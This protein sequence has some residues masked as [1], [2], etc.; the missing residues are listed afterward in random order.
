[1]KPLLVIIAVIAVAALPCAAQ[2]AV[3]FVNQPLIPASVAPGG[4]GFT[5]TVNGTGFV[6]GSTVNWNGSPRTT[7]FISGSQVTANIL[8]TD[9]ATATT[10]SITVFSPAPGGGTSN[11]VFLP[12]RESS[13]F[14]SLNTSN[15]EPE[16]AT[17]VLAAADF[18]N[19]GKQDL[20]VATD[21]V[22]SY[23]IQIL[24]GNGDG[25]F[26][27]SAEYTLSRPPFGLLI[28]DLNG[29]GNLDLVATDLV[30]S[31]N[32]Q[33]F[34]VFLG[35]GD[36]TFQQPVLYDNNAAC[37]HAALVDI[38]RDGNLDVVALYD[39]L[40]CVS[41]GNGNGSFQPA[42][43]TNNLPEQFNYFAVGDLNA[44][45]KLDLAMTGQSGNGSYYLGILLGNGNG[46]FQTAQLTTLTNYPEGITT[47]DFNGDGILDLAVADNG[48]SVVL[49]FLG[50]GDGTFRTPS[51]LPV[52]LEP[53]GVSAAD[54][55]GDGKLDLVVGDYGYAL[56]SLSILLGNGDGTFQNYADYDALYSGFSAIAD[57]N[58]DG[59]LD[60]AAPNYLGGV[61]VMLQ[62]NGT[63]AM[64]SSKSVDFATQLVGAVSQP[65]LVTLTNVGTTPLTI[66]NISVSQ[67]FSELNNC[68]TVQP[69]GSCR[70]ATYFTPT[71]TGTL[72]GYIAIADNGGGSPQLINLS[73]VATIVSLSPSSLNFGDQ[74]VGTVSKSQNV[75]L[76]NEG[77]SN[78]DISKIGI[79]G[80]NAS[81]FSEVNACASKIAAGGSCTI[82]VL[83]HPNAQGAA[84]A[85]LEVEDNGGGSPQKVPL[86][87][88][89]T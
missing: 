39:N 70:I 78:L 13:T 34:G 25:T 84:S 37:C 59:R 57:F 55:N 60:I 3:P 47:A 22:N 24:L 10:A 8:A 68:R 82:T 58:G 42:N 29:D 19:D 88:T 20:A 56:A 21:N 36:G 44:D 26:T 66:S 72:I 1:M 63:T 81:D 33:A 80:A 32:N 87:G 11:V 15:F 64:L 77:N 89:G 48:D 43:C 12:V 67:Y 23:L 74:K 45:G 38:N 54:M 52:P 9:I 73:G 30:D 4:A 76:T 69:N 65:K 75:T 16:L 2:N 28:A 14:V 86:S 83:F 18:N 46:T 51:R 31:Q 71:T 49:L 40:L 62:D 53:F 61:A 6:S 41:L 35:N 5:L 7:T 27:Q 50:N 17:N 79:G 85:T